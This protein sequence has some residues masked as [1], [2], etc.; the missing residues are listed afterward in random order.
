MKLI[1]VSLLAIQVVSCRWL[2]PCRRAEV[3]RILKEAVEDVV[4]SFDL[5]RINELNRTCSSGIVAQLQDV[6]EAVEHTSRNGDVDECILPLVAR[7]E[8][9]LN[10]HGVNIASRCQAGNIKSIFRDAVSHTQRCINRP[11]ASCEYIRKCVA[12]DN[13]E[14]KKHIVRIVKEYTGCVLGEC[15][16][17]QRDIQRIVW[18]IRAC[19]LETTSDAS[20]PSSWD[21]TGVPY[22]PNSSNSTSD[23]LE[24]T[25]VTSDEDDTPST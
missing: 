25:E 7:V 15:R 16:A 4:R 13:G 1:I 23:D 19:A 3:Q 24:E 20:T 11:L 18:E 22:E 8:E 12:A 9:A 17:I 2:L 21:D 10:L 6:Q 14:R 5:H